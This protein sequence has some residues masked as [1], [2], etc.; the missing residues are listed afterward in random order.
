LI[1][2]TQVLASV[3]LIDVE[4]PWFT[5]EA[6]DRGSAVHRAT[7]LLDEGRLDW[8]SIESDAVM[9]ERVR[10]YENW[11]NDE[12]GVRILRREF[13]AVHEIYDYVGHPD[14]LGEDERGTFVMDIKSPMECDWHGAQL[15]AYQRA[16]WLEADM[17]EAGDLTMSTKEGP[18]AAPNR[19]YNLYLGA[20]FPRGYRVKLHDD[21]SDWQLFLAALSVAKFKEARR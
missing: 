2:V 15:A 1:S 3:G 14:I 18:P 11:R 5:K 17:R 21:R 4:A 20:N 16:I 12:P 13:E 8:S 10:G 7:E 9:T 19:R 6:R